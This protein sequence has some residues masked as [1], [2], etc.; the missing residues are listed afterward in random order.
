MCVKWG[1]IR[2]LKRSSQASVEEAW[3]PNGNLFISTRL[4]S[5][6]WPWAASSSSNGSPCAGYGNVPSA[7]CSAIDEA[8]HSTTSTKM[9]RRAA[10]ATFRSCG[11]CFITPTRPPW[12]IPNGPR[13][14]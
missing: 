14:V 13:Y 8:A 7:G 11:L 10:M 3:I 5:L 9:C 2:I 1:R 12:T 6:L 4:A